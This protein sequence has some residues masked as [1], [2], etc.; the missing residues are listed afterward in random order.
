MIAVI[1]RE[2]SVQ[3]VVRRAVGMVMMPVI[4]FPFIPFAVVIMIVIIEPMRLGWYCK[5][6]ET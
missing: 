2:T 1:S 3:G 5:E 4:E 6:P